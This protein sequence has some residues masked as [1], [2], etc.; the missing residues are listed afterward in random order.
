M[1][2]KKNCALPN[3]FLQISAN[4]FLYEGKY[5]QNGRKLVQRRRRNARTI[6]TVWSLLLRS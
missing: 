3:I 5:F 2:G 1:Y 4:K 6:E